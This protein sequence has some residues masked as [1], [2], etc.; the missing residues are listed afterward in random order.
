MQWN[1]AIALRQLEDQDLLAHLDD[2][3]QRDNWRGVLPAP[4]FQAISYNGHVI[5]A[6]LDIQNVS[7]MFY[8]TSIFKQ[9]GLEP[10][11][12][13]DEFFTVA[14]RIKQ[15][16]YIPLAQS[17]Q[18]AFI[19]SLWATVL[20]GTVGPQAYRKIY[21]EHDARTAGSP[22]VVHAFETLRRL[23]AYVDPG[24]N[25][26]KWNDTALLIQ[27]G[28]AA[29]FIMGDWAKGEFN[30][31]GQTAGAEFDCVPAP[32][33]RGYEI[34]VVDTF[35]FPKPVGQEAES[36]QQKLVSV[37][38]DPVVQAQ[39]NAAKGALPARMDA[40]M[41][42]LDSCSRIGDQVIHSN[43]GNLLPS[44]NLAFT[45]DQDGQIQDLVSSFW[46]RPSMTAQQAA[47]D[48]ARIVASTD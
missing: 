32:G 36:A 22:A 26:R 16:G 12:T 27:N 14:D 39:F 21:V 2:I 42:A 20:L 5:A 4:I 9:L 1:T 18:P 33:T 7:L 46:S 11:K 35:G 28:K 17:G 40:Q 47:R 10:P 30:A 41:P 34:I 48:F 15:A 19:N 29:M 37:L 25:N 24:S 31:A 38:M 8:N 23:T 13:W 3:A 45:P 43:P 44:S 6:P